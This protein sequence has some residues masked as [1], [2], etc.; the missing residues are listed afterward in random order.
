MGDIADMMIGGDLCE[1]CGMVLDGEGYGIPRY[2]SNECAKDRGYDGTASDGAGRY[3]KSNKHKGE[4][5][6]DVISIKI[7]YNGNKVFYATQNDST[8]ENAVDIAE[9]LTKYLEQALEITPRF[10]HPKMKSAQPKATD[11]TG[12]ELV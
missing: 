3:G 2:C 11:S 6:R 8:F 10:K 12:G 4:R 5:P 7:T 9:Y 1:M